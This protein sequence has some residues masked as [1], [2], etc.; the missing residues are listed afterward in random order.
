MVET[1]TLCFLDVFEV[2]SLGQLLAQSADLFAEGI[3]VFGVVLVEF[4]SSFKYFGSFGEH[5]GRD[6]ITIVLLAAMY[7]GK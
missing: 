4:Y 7:V 5:E 2:T 1:G 3:E 6:G